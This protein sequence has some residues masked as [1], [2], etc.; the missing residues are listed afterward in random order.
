MSIS[1][2]CFCKNGDFILKKLNN[3]FYSKYC[4]S[5]ATTFSIFL[6]AYEFCVERS[7]HLLRLS[8]NRLIFL[9]LHMKRIVRIG[10]MSSIG[11]SGN[12]TKQYQERIAGGDFPIQRFQICFDGLCDIRSSI[13]MLKNYFVVFLR[14]FLFQ[15]SNAS[16]EVDTDLLYWF[17]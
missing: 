9:Y 7:R 2:R 6:A 4:P 5:L 3:V 8:T 15:C 11:I 13:V 16:I 12:Q 10:R 1:S 17:H 14:R